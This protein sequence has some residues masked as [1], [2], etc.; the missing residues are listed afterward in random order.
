MALFMCNTSNIKEMEIGRPQTI[1]FEGEDVK[2]NG[3]IVTLG[4]SMEKEHGRHYDHVHVV[5][6]EEMDSVVG[7][8]IIVAPEINVEQ[9]R[10][11]DGQIG[12]FVLEP[13]VTYT[14]YKLQELDRIEYTDAYFVDAK[15][16]KVGDKVKINAEG[17]FEKEVGEG[18]LRVLT[19]LPTHYPVVM[20][21]GK[22]GQ[23]ISLM[24]TAGLK[25]KLEV[26]R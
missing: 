15:A 26:V 2:P 24:P 23:N 9:Y 4:D 8:Y 25:I 21:P 6:F 3:S 12:K 20:A 22:K 19:V 10:T 7:K 14:A 17:K 18:A 16:L 11:I 5:E 13:N 1:L